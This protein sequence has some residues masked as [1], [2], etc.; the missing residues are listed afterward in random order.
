M[1]N[2]TAVTAALVRPL[3]DTKIVRA[4]AGEALAFGTPVYVSS[5]TGDL[6]IVSKAD[7]SADDALLN[8]VGVVVAGGHDGATSIATDDPCDVVTFGPITGF[9]GMTSGAHIWVSDTVGRLSNVVGT[10][11]CIVGVAL[12]PAIVLV[13]P[14]KF[15]AST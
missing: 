3:P 13:R 14:G 4:Q 10:K 12:T 5:Y 2:E 1:A 7:A 8:C 6:P 9:S 11:S 15:V